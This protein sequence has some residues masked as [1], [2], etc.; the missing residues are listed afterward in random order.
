MAQKQTNGFQTI[1]QK[2]GEQ[3]IDTYL[4]GTGLQVYGTG[5]N[6]I[7]PSIEIV[8]NGLCQHCGNSSS[9]IYQYEGGIGNAFYDDTDEVTL[10][11]ATS[12]DPYLNPFYASWGSTLSQCVIHLAEMTIYG[13]GDSS[14]NYKQAMFEVTCD[15]AFP[16][17]TQTTLTTNYCKSYEASFVSLFDSSYRV[18]GS[19]GVIKFNLDS[20]GSDT[21][22]PTTNDYKWY[23]YYKLRLTR[24][25]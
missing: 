3:S 24:I 4:D 17:S 20:Y 22:T 19:D 1:E 9:Y 15:P 6:M 2:F 10:F 5:V 14:T 7:S 18:N 16:G 25:G 8:T 13:A 23:V 12:E 11:D 21:G